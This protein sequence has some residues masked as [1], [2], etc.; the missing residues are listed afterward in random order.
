MGFCG[1]VEVVVVEGKDGRGDESRG[2]KLT[3][4]LKLFVSCLIVF[5]MLVSLLSYCMK[6][7]LAV[8]R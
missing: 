7:H 1:M 6:K 3:L 5:Y 2:G 8:L 4:F